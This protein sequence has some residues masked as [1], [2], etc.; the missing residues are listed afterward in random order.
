MHGKPACVLSPWIDRKISVMIMNLPA[1]ARALAALVPL[2][3]DNRRDRRNSGHYKSKWLQLIPQ[4]SQ[5]EYV[6]D[7]YSDRGQNNN[8]ERSV[9]DEFAR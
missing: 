4:P 7:A 1:P 9:H 3:E 6:A 5:N 2:H 8:E